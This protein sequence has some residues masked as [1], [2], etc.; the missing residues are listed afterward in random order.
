[1]ANTNPPRGGLAFQM[2]WRTSKYSARSGIGAV[3]AYAMLAPAGD[4]VVHKAYEMK[5]AA[6]PVHPA[7]FAHTGRT[8]PLKLSAEMVCRSR[9]PYIAP[10]AF[11]KQL[12][13]LHQ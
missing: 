4:M 2:K 10:V 12:G 3:K 5:C 7:I 8:C 13:S 11:R 9:L 6:D 1:M